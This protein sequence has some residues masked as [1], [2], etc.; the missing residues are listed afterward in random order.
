MY[1]P[2][3]IDEHKKYVKMEQGT[4]KYNMALL[5]AASGKLGALFWELNQIYLNTLLSRHIPQPIPKS[6]M[7]FP[8]ET[9]KADL[10]R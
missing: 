5:T 10:N 4:V 3:Q 7:E 9:T 1:Q 8:K 6:Q 2:K